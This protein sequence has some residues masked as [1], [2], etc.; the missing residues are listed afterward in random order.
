MLGLVRTSL[1]AMAMHGHVTITSM[2]ECSQ[3]VLCRVGS[4]VAIAMV[5]QPQQQRKLAATVPAAA[6]NEGFQ[7]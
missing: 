7:A 5:E 6:C 4:G 2:Q 1:C 3:M